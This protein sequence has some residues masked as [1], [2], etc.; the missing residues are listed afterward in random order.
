MAGK[1]RIRDMQSNKNIGIKINL[2]DRVFN[3]LGID[4]KTQNLMDVK[5]VI[6]NLY[7][8]Q[9]P[10]ITVKSPRKTLSEQTP[11]N[12]YG[13]KITDKEMRLFMELFGLTENDWFHESISGRIVSDILDGKVAVSNTPIN[14]ESNFIQSTLTEDLQTLGKKK[15]DTTTKDALVSARI[16]QGMFRAQVLQLWDN[17]CCVTRSKTIDAIRASHIKPWRHSTDEER[18]DPYNGLPLVASL[19]ALFDA[20]LISFES[21]GALIV[22][23]SFPEGERSIFQVESRSLTKA[24]NEATAEYLAY[25][26]N[27]VFRK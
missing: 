3:M 7:G 27:H 14:K 23:T 24:P 16:G 26:R 2:A 10:E 25:H 18:L 5:R 9:N 13:I 6:F 19:D 11:N 4:P 21:S 1:K 20:G 22:S 8:L 15:I 12:A 17:R